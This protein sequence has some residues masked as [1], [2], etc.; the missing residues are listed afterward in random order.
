MDDWTRWVNAARE[1]IER[2]VADASVALD[3][4]SASVR[5]DS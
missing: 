1:P 2:E 4:Q 5:L 3:A